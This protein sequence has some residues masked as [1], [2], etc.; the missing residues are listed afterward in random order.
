MDSHWKVLS[1]C[2]WPCCHHITKGK[3]APSSTWQMKGAQRSFWQEK[4][5]TPRHLRCQT[6]HTDIDWKEWY[7]PTFL[8]KISAYFF[9]PLELKNMVDFRITPFYLFIYLFVVV[10]ERCSTLLFWPALV[11]YATISL[12]IIFITSSWIWHKIIHVEDFR[13]WFCYNFLSM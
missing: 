12:Y 6:N 10:E 9:S 2:S 7:P 5:C 1:V 11:K 8:S 13:P 3:W 4:I